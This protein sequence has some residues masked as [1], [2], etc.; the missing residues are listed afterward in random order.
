MPFG[1]FTPFEN[2][3]SSIGLKT[4][5]NSYQSFSSG[6]SR[7]PLNIKNRKIDLNLLPLICYEIIYSGKLSKD[8]NLII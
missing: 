3:L 7:I 4:I 2:V 5:T 8:N 1:E 6:E